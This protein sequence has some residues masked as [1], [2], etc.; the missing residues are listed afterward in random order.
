VPFVCV[1]VRVCVREREG[2]KKLGTVSVERDCFS[3][4]CGPWVVLLRAHVLLACLCVCVSARRSRHSILVSMCKQK[5]R[6]TSVIP[7][8]SDRLGEPQSRPL[9]CAG[10]KNVAVQRIKAWQSS[11]KPA[12]LPTELS[13]RLV[14]IG[15]GV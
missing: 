13:Q 7:V 11:L 1:L 8:P 14:L 9:Q 5:W 6:S 3:A 4:G 15:A 2:G 10:K 12:T